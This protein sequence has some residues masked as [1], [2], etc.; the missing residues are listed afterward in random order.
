MKLCSLIGL[1]LIVGLSPAMGA[2]E[3]RGD[4][5]RLA[6]WNLYWLSAEPSSGMVRR[7]VDDYAH[8]RFWG[9]SRPQMVS[10]WLGFMMTPCQSLT[11]NWLAMSI[12]ARLLWPALT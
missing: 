9:R 11:G 12:E 8:L 6:T 5:L 7:S 2:A 3:T 1:L 10:A 4:E